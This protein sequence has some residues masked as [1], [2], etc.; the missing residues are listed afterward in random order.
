MRRRLKTRYDRHMP[1]KKH[2]RVLIWVVFFVCSGVV[3]GQLLYP[4]DRALPLARVAHQRVTWQGHDELAKVLEN[5]F[6]ATTLQLTVGDKS[7]ELPLASAGAELNTERMIDTLVAYPFWQRFIPF[8]IVVHTQDI[9]KADV[10]Y[11]ESILKKVSEEQ[12]KKL[13]FAAVD[14]RLAIENGVL[15]ATAEEQGSEVTSEAVYKAITS[16]SVQLG[17][18]TTLAVS[19]KRTEPAETARNLQAVR[20]TAEAALARQVQVTANGQAFTPDRATVASWLRIAADTDGKPTLE[21]VTDTLSVFFDSIDAKVGVPAGRTNI[22]LTDGRETSR[23]TGQTGTAINRDELQTQL[24]EW[25]LSGE[26]QGTFMASFHDVAPSVMYDNK[27]TATEEGLRAYVTDASR[28]MN[29][30][31]AIQQV[32]GGKWSAS[33]RADESIPSAST[34]KLFVAKWLF[35]QMDKGIVHWDDPMLDTTV[36]VCFDRM[37]IASTNP[38]AESWLAQAGRP[39][40][41]QYI[42]GLG[43]SQGTNFNMPDATHTTANDLQRMMLGIN[44]NTIMKGANK[45]RLLHSLST[46]PYRYGIPTGSGGQVYDKVGFLWDYVHD[47]AIVRHPKGTYV[48]TIMTKGQSYATIAS[49]TR[50][51]ERIM[52]P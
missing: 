12:A 32:D 34:Y 2:H 38:C 15:I 21:I 45:D 23:T 13:S 37:T 40:F 30:R 51:I 46:H 19:A 10:Y 48:M 11:T 24:V 1:N 31:I 25:L 7:V 43:F 17:G 26:G 14:A 44:D 52:Y 28:R 6:R 16:A 3:A 50:E 22:N 9:T 35:D 4:V 47:T 36:S 41:N 33:A 20:A 42:W 49:L 29:V 27:Y 18:T 5:H 8:S 39:Q